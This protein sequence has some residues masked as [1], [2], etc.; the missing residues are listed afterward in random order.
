MNATMPMLLVSTVAA[1]LAPQAAA[2]EPN[3]SKVSSRRP[4]DVSVQGL[5]EAIR[6]APDGRVRGSNLGLS[7]GPVTGVDGD[8]LSSIADRATGGCLT[9]S[10]TPTLGALYP[11]PGLNNVFAP[12]AFIGGGEN[13]QATGP[14]STI[15]GGQG[16]L[17]SG[18][19]ATVGGGQGNRARR[20]FATVGGGYGNTAAW[21]YSTVGGGLNNRATGRSL[22]A[23]YS[24][25]GGGKD[26]AA[27]DTG[28]TVGGGI[29]NTAEGRHATVPGGLANYAGGS[30]SFAAG[31]RARAAHN[32]AFVWGDSFDGDKRSSA[33]DQFN[34]Y[35]GGG[36]RMFTNSAA[37]T[38]VLLA[39][40]GST[41]TMVSDRDAKE[42]VEPVDARAVLDKVAELPLATW[43]YKAQDDSIRHMGPMAQD[44][45]AAFGLGLGEKTIDTIDPNGV[46]LAAI[47][48]LNEVVREKDA[49]IEELR[50]ANE[51]LLARIERLEAL[52]RAALVSEVGE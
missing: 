41:W 7:V 3:P 26:N 48:G 49:E 20:L 45:H 17:V 51:A 33:V 46:A 11:Y 25:V 8:C 14:W 30:H 9:A 18:A 24:T 21:F 27:I 32:G 2:Q 29:S 6:R 50:T 37:T 39:A 13:N 4:V 15:G 12:L 43:N 22:V 10:S 40:G 1:A 28:S 23:G 19:H 31:R 44:F 38:G 36:V 35:A 47:Q 16:N 34:V 52:A 42:N 5:G